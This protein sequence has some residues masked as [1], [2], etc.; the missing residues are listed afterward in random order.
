MYLDDASLTSEFHDIATAVLDADL[1]EYD[2]WFYSYCGR[3][4][5]SDGAAKYV[6]HVLDL[7]NLAE[8]DV[9]GARVLDA[10]CGFGMTTLLC[11]LLGAAEAHGIDVHQGMLDTA[12]AYLPLLPANLA[13]R[14]GVTRGDVSCMP[15]PA[16]S[17]DVVL[18]IEAVSH[19]LFVEKFL[20]EAWRV[21]KPGGVLIV[22]DGN[23]G[24][25]PLVRRRAYH[26]WEAFEK[27]PVGA[28]LAGHTA[29]CYREM[30]REFIDQHFPGLTEAEASA[31]T[32]HTFA[33]TFDEV[34]EACERY[35]S[36]GLMP[37]RTFRRGV[38]AIDPAGAAIERLFDPNALGDEMAKR[39]FEVRVVGYW[40]GASG[41]PA[42]RIANRILTRLSPVTIYSA[43]AF[44][45]VAVKP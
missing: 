41:R 3:L 28:H 20:A 33:M 31:L 29:Q 32:E 9:R 12:R 11:G 14:V 40:G 5:S 17:Y 43:R 21:L 2:Q 4:R 19:Y 30:R 34:R 44:R 15:C 27:G 42:L 7:L 37:G 36:D 23:N 22:S 13:A 39:G 16:E 18:S 35:V 8:R 6:R 24:L 1:P 45:T 25:N 26:M 38:P 10:G